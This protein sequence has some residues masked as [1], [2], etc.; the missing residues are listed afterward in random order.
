MLH[1][2]IWYFALS[3]DGYKT[4]DEYLESDNLCL[5]SIWSSV[6]HP[7]VSFALAMD[8]SIGKS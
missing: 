8:E 3:C 6:N 4:F 7:L 2:I 5:Q 1:F